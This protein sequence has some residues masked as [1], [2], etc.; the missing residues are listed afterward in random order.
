[1]KG[2][3]GLPQAVD[4]EG[5][6]LDSGKEWNLVG[7]DVWAILWTRLALAGRAAL[8]PVCAHPNPKP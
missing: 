6:D 2:R 4:A 3:T 7:C 1:M 8:A 5:N